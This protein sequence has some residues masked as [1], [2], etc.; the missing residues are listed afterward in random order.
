MAHLYKF[1]HLNNLI[2]LGYD[3]SLKKIMIN[4]LRSAANALTEFL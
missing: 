3:K 1:K 2:P 4:D